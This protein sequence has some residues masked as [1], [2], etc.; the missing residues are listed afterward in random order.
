MAEIV[1]VTGFGVYATLDTGGDLELAG[2]ADMGITLDEFIERH[3]GI[4]VTGFDGSREKA[5]AVKKSV[6]DSLRS[7]YVK[8]ETPG[9]MRDAQENFIKQNAG[10]ARLSGGYADAGLFSADIVGPNGEVVALTSKSSDPIRKGTPFYDENATSKKSFFDA[11]GRRLSAAEVAKTETGKGFAAAGWD[12]GFGPGMIAPGVKADTTERDAYLAAKKQDISQTSSR[13]DSTPLIPSSSQSYTSSTPPPPPAK[14]AP[15]DTV[16]FDD[17]SVPIEVMTDL[18]FEN[19]GGQELI[20]I[21]RNDIVNGQKISYFPIKNLTSI[22]QQYNPNNIISL[23][24]TS[25][26]YFA[27]FP[28]DID[29]KIPN[30]GN[31]PNGTNVYIE[32]STGDLIIE[33]INI[34]SDEQ[35]DIQIAISGTIYEVN[36]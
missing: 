4:N 32:E 11:T 3:G 17:D 23:Q 6:E 22:Q 21:A 26:K 5:A 33:T 20:N 30:E 31:G 19:I 2:P 1:D 8:Y 16:L 24:S 15:I 7:G 12:I 14:T 25:D 18:I 29:K 10:K 27:N 34:E 13:V 28:I 36:I 35:V 9:I